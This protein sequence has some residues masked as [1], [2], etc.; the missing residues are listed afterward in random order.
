M[1]LSQTSDLLR[2]Q[3]ISDVLQGN[4]GTCHFFLC[5]DTVPIRS[6]RQGKWIRVL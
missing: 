5:G 3:S 2:A 1:E 6:K 4:E